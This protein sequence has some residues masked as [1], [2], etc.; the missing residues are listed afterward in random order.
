MRKIAGPSFSTKKEKYRKVK[1]DYYAHQSDMS[2]VVSTFDL[3]FRKLDGNFEEA[4]QDIEN[5]RYLDAKAILTRQGWAGGGPGWENHGLP[6]EYL[7]FDFECHPDKL[8]S[9]SSHYDEMIQGG[10]PLHHILLAERYGRDESGIEASF[11][12]GSES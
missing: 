9:L 6:S 8:A 7:S 4:D 5:A 11:G 12:A 3:L 2:L 10:Y 1:Q